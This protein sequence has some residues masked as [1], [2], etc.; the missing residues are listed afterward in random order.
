MSRPAEHSPPLPL[1]TLNV[2]AGGIRSA[3]CPR[4]ATVAAPLP[5]R[6]LDTARWQWVVRCRGCRTVFRAREATGGRP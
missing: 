3:Q 6:P 2:S 5:A 4:C 1:V